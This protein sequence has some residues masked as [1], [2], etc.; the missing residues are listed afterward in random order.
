MEYAGRDEEGYP[1]YIVPD[2]TFKKF[3]DIKKGNK[4][5]IKINL[6][7]AG[8][9]NL[10]NEEL[11]KIKRELECFRNGTCISFLK[12]PIN[13]LIDKIDNV[14][15]MRKHSKY[16][17]L[18]FDGYWSKNNISPRQH[19]GTFYRKVRR[20][21][22]AKMPKFFT[23]KINDSAEIEWAITVVHFIGKEHGLYSEQI[24]EFLSNFDRE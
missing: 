2:E 12:D 10:D 21:I 5:I 18:K 3:W 14:I 7:I 17:W 24:N 8:L 6:T 20:D 13:R 23:H 16:V 19:V 4:E 11:E 22:A 15:W 9:K 1:I